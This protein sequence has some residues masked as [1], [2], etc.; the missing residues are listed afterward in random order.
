MARTK[1]SKA[2]DARHS[3][4]V[5]RKPASRPASRPANTSTPRRTD[6]I[7]AM[8]DPY[9]QQIIDGKKTYEFR[10]YN[11][12]G[13]ERIWFYRTAPHSAIT[14]ICPVQKAATRREGDPPLPEDGLGNAEYNNK[15]LD[16][17]GY[18]Y[19]YRIKGVYEIQAA[20]GKG[21]TWAMMRDE[22]GMKSA[23]RGRVSVPQSMLD[24][25]KIGEQE[26]K[27]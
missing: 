21:I 8:N 24:Q 7:L 20:G 9:M 13:I 25:Y 14:H 1:T 11:M 3:S 6:M 17:E 19:A 27:W 16:Y 12:A 23:P 22:H 4:R 5:R 10:K 2:K 26:K 18:D 15:H